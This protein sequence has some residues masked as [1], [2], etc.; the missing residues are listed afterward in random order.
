MSFLNAGTKTRLCMQSDRAIT[1]SRLSDRYFLL[2]CGNGQEANES[3][4]PHSQNPKNGHTKIRETIDNR[5]DLNDL[6][7]SA[8]DRFSTS[9]AVPGSSRKIDLHETPYNLWIID[10][11]T[12]TAMEVPDAI[13]CIP[14]STPAIGNLSTLILSDGSSDSMI[15]DFDID[16][17][18]EKL[19]RGYQVLWISSEGFYGAFSPSSDQYLLGTIGP[20][21]IR[22]KFY[23]EGEYILFSTLRYRLV[24]FD[25]RDAIALLEDRTSFELLWTG[26]GFPAR[27]EIVPSD[28]LELLPVSRGGL[29]PVSDLYFAE[30]ALSDRPQPTP[31]E[32]VTH[33]GI[34][35]TSGHWILPPLFSRMAARDL[36]EIDLESGERLFFASIGTEFETLGIRVIGNASLH[37]SGLDSEYIETVS[38]PSWPNTHARYLIGKRQQG[39]FDVLRSI[40]FDVIYSIPSL[41]R[42]DVAG[43]MWGEVDF[44][45]SRFEEILSPNCADRFYPIFFDSE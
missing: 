1:I 14:L 22:S 40:N 25:P 27:L 26:P 42:W 9:F 23:G 3:R 10:L 28:A 34:A 6:L 24:A 16:G 36:R 41:S 31:P 13:N 18:L 12:L 38:S 4:T 5:S 8:R 33:Y 2:D 37:R 29:R 7:D 20:D 35:A 11:N 19:P 45:G 17:H 44:L 21:V 39:H 32:A 43:L 30:R 15:V